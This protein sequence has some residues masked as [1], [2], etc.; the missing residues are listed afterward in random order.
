MIWYYDLEPYTKN[1][2]MTHLPNG[3]FRSTS[4]PSS[5]N[6]KVKQGD[7]VIFFN[8]KHSKLYDSMVKRGAHVFPSKDVTYKLRNRATQLQELDTITKF[9]LKREYIEAF[10]GIPKPNREL[11]IIKTGDN[12][13]GIGKYK[14][15]DAPRKML[16]HESV[17]YEE[18]VENHRGIR[19]LIIGDDTFL[20]EQVNPDTWIKNDRPVDEIT[21]HWDTQIEEAL[22]W[23]PCAQELIWDAHILLDHIKGSLIGIDYA[24]GSDKIGL[25]EANDMV[26]I[27]DNE[28]AMEC[29]NK[30]LLKYSEVY[31]RLKND[32][33]ASV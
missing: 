20:I 11:P 10:T 7:M 2:L 24:V 16:R 31:L 28:F 22:K 17:V 8:Y 1:F 5:L 13:Q 30:L 23:L 19:V 3:S 15:P 9:P 26:G 25:L 12:H 18:F 6:S 32:Y 4:D 27:P 14:F 21:Y 33:S 29:F